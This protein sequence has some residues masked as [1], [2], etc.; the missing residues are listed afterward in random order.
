MTTEREIGD[1]FNYGSKNLVVTQQ[2]NGLLCSGCY[3]RDK[4]CFEIIHVGGECTIK[5]KDG[6]KVI[7]QEIRL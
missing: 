2:K 5:R 6:I 3:L 7:F 1:I 4:R